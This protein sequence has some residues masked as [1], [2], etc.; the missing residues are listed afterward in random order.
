MNVAS[1]SFLSLLFAGQNSRTKRLQVKQKKVVQQSKACLSLWR[2]NERQIRW[3]PVHKSITSITT[4]GKTHLHWGQ[5]VWVQTVF[6]ASLT[7]LPCVVC[8]IPALW[9]VP[10]S[11]LISRECEVTAFCTLLWLVC[12][13]FFK[14]LIASSSSFLTYLFPLSRARRKSR[15]SIRITH[16]LQCNSL[17]VFS[18]QIRLIHLPKWPR[19][20]VI[21]LVL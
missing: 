15:A 14:L 20:S 16:M 17:F 4:G 18:E 1:D 9:H 21:P 12:F 13:L 6:R 5:N 8:K 11:W 10:H 2:G 3:A 7:I 19:Q